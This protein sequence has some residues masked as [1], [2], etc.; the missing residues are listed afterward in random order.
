MK[1]IPNSTLLMPEA[2]IGV[3][4]RL[5]KDIRDKRRDVD[6]E[7]PEYNARFPFPIIHTP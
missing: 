5:D 2:S 1:M 7:V 4:S 6:K 3:T